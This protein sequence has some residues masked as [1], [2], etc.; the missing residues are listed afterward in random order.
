MCGHLA[1]LA[2]L[3]ATTPDENKKRPLESERLGNTRTLPIT[4]I[5]ATGTHPTVLPLASAEHPSG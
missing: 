4:S 3:T 2:V 5:I 1:A